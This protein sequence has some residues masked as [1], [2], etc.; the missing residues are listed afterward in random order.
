MSKNIIDIHTFVVILY[1]VLFPLVMDHDNKSVQCV[2]FNKQHTIHSYY[3]PL[4]VTPHKKLDDL[5]AKGR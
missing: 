4:L 2:F 3:L 1:N 5:W